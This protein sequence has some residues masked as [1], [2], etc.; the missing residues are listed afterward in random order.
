MLSLYSGQLDPVEYSQQARGKNA[1]ILGF[2][3]SAADE[4]VFVT[5]TG[6]DIYTITPQKKAIKVSNN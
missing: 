3:W 1:A 2:F 5:E 6:I 4:I